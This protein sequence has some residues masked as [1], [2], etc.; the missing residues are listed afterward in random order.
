MSSLGNILSKARDVYHATKPAVSAMKGMM[1][2][3]MRQ[4]AEAVGY[5]NSGGASGGRSGGRSGGK[6]SI[7]DRIM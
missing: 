3:Q 1:P 5:G 2:E 6:K 4:V 7:A